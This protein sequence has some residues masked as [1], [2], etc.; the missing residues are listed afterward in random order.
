[1]VALGHFFEEVWDLS[2]RY[3]TI[4]LN[5]KKN[6]G[7]NDG[8]NKTTFFE[9]K[10]R[11]D[12][13]KGSNA[14]KEIKSKLETSI[15]NGKNFFLLIMTDINNTKRN[16]PLHKG[17]G[18]NVIKNVTGYDETKHRWISED[19]VYEELFPHY[20]IKVKNKI[21]ECLSTLKFS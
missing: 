4:L 10:S 1:V 17:V 11:Y 16:I 20:P 12:T 14:K 13:M 3:D 2:N 8:Q 19:N 21:L 9:S 7:G 5:N 18:L 15:K 6:T